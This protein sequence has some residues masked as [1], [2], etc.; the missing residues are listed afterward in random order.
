[1]QR[2]YFT[3]RILV[4]LKEKG[5]TRRVNHWIKHDKDKYER[6]DPSSK[7]RECQEFFKANADRISN[8][9]AILADEK[10]RETFK[11][12]LDYRMYKNPIPGHLY[13]EH[14]QYFIDEMRLSDG[15]V[16]VDGGGYTGDTIQQLMDTAKRQSVCVK[17][18]V[19]FEPDE[20]N[21]KIISRFYGKRRGISIYKAGLSDKEQVLYFKSDGATA[22]IVDDERMASHKINTAAIDN[23]PECRDATYIKMDIEGAE[24][25]ALHGAVN[26]IQ[27]NKPKLAICIYHSDE[28]MLRL[29][30]LVHSIMPSYRLMIRH[31]SR[32]DVETVLYATI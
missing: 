10:S 12:C 6:L 17:R 29:I 11:A 2:H 28:D 21:Y 18:I 32:G 9:M 19:V 16:F 31:H 3:F 1:M 4:W 26:V 15:E 7:M 30:E 5:I 25:D 24:W 22:R 27:Q 14:D 13:S 23:H 20:T 8:I